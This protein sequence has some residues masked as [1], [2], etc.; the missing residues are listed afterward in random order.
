MHTIV[1]I[2]PGH[3]HAGLVLR[4]MHPKLSE[5]VYIYSEPGQDL[6]NYLKLI[7]SFNKREQNPTKWQFHIYTGQD[8]LEKAVAE[9]RGDIAILAGR[10]DRK[11]YDIEAL[12]NA[13]FKVLSDKPLT[14][15]E[16][17]V[18]T[19][20]KVVA[21]GDVVMD[22]MTE[23]HEA[24]S[25]IQKELLK[26]SE[27]FGGFAQQE[28]PVIFKESVHFLAKVVNGVQLVR[29]AWYF[30]VKKQ[31]EGLVDVTTHLVDLVQEMTAGKKPIDFDQDVKV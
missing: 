29:P 23:R 15:D 9:K 21:D 2:N 4:Q 30:D 28:E 3:F 14:I 1:I 17:G 24:T 8:Y 11:I 18:A 6:D 26:N 12:H 13:G 7:E 10:N 19:L 20:A 25:I 22:I 5:H 16:R 31:G 27:I